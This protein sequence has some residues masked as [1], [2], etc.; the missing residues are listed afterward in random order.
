MK[1]I[2]NNLTSNTDRLLTLTNELTRAKLDSKTLTELTHIAQTTLLTKLA[3]NL[4]PT[5]TKNLRK[6]TYNPNLILKPVDKNMGISIIH[7]P[8]Y[9]E[10]CNQHL[11]STDYLKLTYNP[12]SETSKTVNDSLTSLLNNRK[13][14]ERLYKQ[15][16]PPVKCRLG[17]FYAL[18]KLHKKLLDIRPIVSS[19]NHPTERISK[20][21]HHTL[22]QSAKKAITYIGSSQEL[23][24]K[25][26]NI[27]PTQNT[28]IITADIRSL[29]TRIDS[30]AGA[31]LATE[32]VYE[33]MSIR[34]NYD[35]QTFHTLLSLV[36]LSNTFE[37]DEEY[38]KQ[39]IGTAMGSRMAPG[40]ANTVLKRLE[41]KRLLRPHK[42]HFHNSCFT[43]NKNL[44]FFGR[45][46]DDICIIYE[47]HDNSLPSFIKALRETYAPLELELNVGKKANFLDLTIY[48]DPLTNKFSTNLF[49]KPLD[50]KEPV[51]HSSNHP[52][53]VLDNI[54]SQE[55]SRIKSLCSNYS[56]ELS[57]RTKFITKL[58][59][60]GFD[61]NLILRKYNDFDKPKALRTLN[62]NLNSN[63][64]LP[65]PPQLN[66]T[67]H[68]NPTNETPIPKHIIL[69]YNQ[70]AAAV[71]KQ[72]RS[73]Q[74]HLEPS[75][76][77]LITYRS[78]K[79]IKSKLI[80]AK[81]R[82]SN[83]NLHPIPQT[84]PKIFKANTITNYFKHIKTTNDIQTVQATTNQHNSH[85][86]AA[87][88]HHTNNAQAPH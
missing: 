68:T 83:P 53:H 7:K 78:E 65:K 29:Y 3:P 77:H 10:L 79:N 47:N 56:D 5:E 48:I 62:L 12:L 37:H 22:I 44:S 9:L 35:G 40:Y 66:L 36:L 51:H 38:F 2:P 61:Y 21:L 81:L 52:R 58:L 54:V 19:I 59:Q 8:L 72:I 20:H 25:L 64:T 23:I 85:N 82:T 42:S 75:V 86:Y 71:T 39:L 57:H 18:P 76:R 28:F 11:N 1:F 41:E 63:P 50:A 45:Y 26:Q 14:S 67:P 60:Q 24:K 46:I 55:F 70:A 84:N 16:K 87:T 73:Q 13:I 34:K 43:L 4:T 32:E 15:L 17:R 49:R 88:T 27:T 74:Q 33:D 69:T 31:G 80:R 30:K 6:L